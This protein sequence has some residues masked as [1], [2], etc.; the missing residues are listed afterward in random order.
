MAF[1]VPNISIGEETL[2]SHLRA[3]DIPFEREFQFHPV[4]KWRFDFLLAQPSKNGRRIAV[5]V[6]GSAHGGGRHQRR[7]GFQNDLIKLNR[8]QIMGYMVL[9]YTTQDVKNGVA[10]AEIQEALGV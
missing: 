1:K 2:A 6:D 4:R 10:I 3:Y 7:E 5:E 8:A 9:R